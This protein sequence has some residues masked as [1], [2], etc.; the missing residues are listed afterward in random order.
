MPTPR[1]STEIREEALAGLSWPG[2]LE[3][4]VN[5]GEVR[6][7]GQVDSR[8]D[9]ES[10]PITVRHIVGVVSVDSELSGWDPAGKR[11]VA[12]AARL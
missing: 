2:A 5:E 3:L 9:A 1:S 12:I 10:L 7:R 4:D 8:F 11:Q 6:L